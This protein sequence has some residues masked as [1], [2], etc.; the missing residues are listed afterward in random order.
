MYQLMT[1]DIRIKRTVDRIHREYES[2]PQNRDGRG[3]KSSIRTEVTKSLNSLNRVFHHKD[4]QPD[5]QVR[6]R[7][8][9]LIRSLFHWNFMDLSKELS[10]FRSVLYMSGLRRNEKIRQAEARVLSF[11]GKSVLELEEVLTTSL[12]QKVGKRLQLCVANLTVA[13]DYLNERIDYGTEYWVVRRNNVTIGLVEI[14]SDKIVHECNAL[15][16]ACLQLTHEE[17]VQVWESLEVKDSYVETFA[18]VGVYS[19]IWS[20]RIRSSRP[21]PVVIGSKCHYV[22]RTRR[23]IVLA[24]TDSKYQFAERIDH[25]NMGWSHFQLLDKSWEEDRHNHIGLGE[26]LDLVTRSLP[27]QIAI[28]SI[29]Y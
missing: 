12:M 17:A 10:K 13:R 29:R 3:V 24:T 16:N 8:N 18:Q 1:D 25:S 20:N 23:E 19:S 5:P 28:T 27:F 6:H 7:A 26:I 21:S 14:D 9:K 11:H 15:E 4:K 22:W 2:K